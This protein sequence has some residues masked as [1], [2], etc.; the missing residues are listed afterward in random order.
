MW[1]VVKKYWD[2]IGGA[3][4]GLLIAYLARFDLERVQ[5]SYSLIILI[6]AS[7]G[8]LRM[9]KQA[10]EKHKERKPNIIDSIVDG[11][12]AVK[13][14]SIAVEP[15]KEGEKIG[16]ILLG[17]LEG[18]KSIM[19]KLKELFDKYKGYLLTIALGVLSLVENYG[20]Y[21]N[22]V[23][24]GKLVLWGYEVVP[25][26]TLVAALLVGILSNGYTKDQKDKIKALFSKSSTSEL[27]QAE[28]KKTIKEK[29][30]SLTEYNK[31]HNIKENEIANLQSEL[32]TRKNTHAAKKE[33]FNMVPQ[34]ATEEDVQLAANEVVDTEARIVEKTKELDSINSTIEMLKTTIN[35]LKSQL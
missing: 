9:V 27:V 29:S 2:I 14:V 20:G 26:I 3:L 1:Q 32:E 19:K 30:T 23:C 35:A 33:M 7:I 22:A 18:V 21:I 6:L 24:G 12:I 10:I 4:A 15:T 17:I 13:A 8:V 5:L 16:K 11:T 28:I 25:V 34:L 31:L